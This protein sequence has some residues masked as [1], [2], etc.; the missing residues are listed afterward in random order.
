MY[1]IYKTDIII[2]IIFC[3]EKKKCFK[4]LYQIDIN[5]YYNYFF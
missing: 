3:L 4:I 1:I 2:E 5:N